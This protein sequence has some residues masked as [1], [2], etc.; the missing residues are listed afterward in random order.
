MAELQSNDI[1]RVV[2]TAPRLQYDDINA[3]LR[4]LSG[5]VPIENVNVADGVATMD[6]H[7]S[8]NLA[9]MQRLLGDEFKV[10]RDETS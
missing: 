10:G 5:H 8:T 1:Q 4:R 2:V 9:R 3:A 7:N 6:V